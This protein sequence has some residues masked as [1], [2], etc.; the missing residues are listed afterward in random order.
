MSLPCLLLFYILVTFKAISG[1]VPI[2]D[3]EHLWWLYSAAPLGGQTAST[4]TWYSNQ[5]HNRVTEP[6][7]PC[8]IL[9]M[10]SDWLLRSDKYQFFSHWFDSTRV[11]IHE[12]QNSQ[13]SQN[14][15]IA[16]PRRSSHLILFQ[17]WE[18]SVPRWWWVRAH[19]DGWRFVC[20]CFTS[21]QHLRS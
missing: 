16:L 11:W 19:E 5:S 21:Y 6:T 12:V 9:I 14:E 3:S 7:S 20:C 13:F 17:K 10:P 8:Y 15:M 18:S 4:M 1:W 2:Y